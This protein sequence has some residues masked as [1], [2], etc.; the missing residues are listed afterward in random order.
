MPLTFH[1]RLR[2]SMVL[3]LFASPLAAEDWPQFRGPNC[4]G[5]STAK[6]P[7]P[8][9]FSKSQN[10]CWMADLGDAVSS[11]SVADGRVFTTAMLGPRE[12][13]QKFVVFAF[14]AGT[15]RELWQKSFNPVPK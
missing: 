7:L 6:K 5:V 9:K 15:G 8:V 14:D 13:K 10:V 11:P 2:W 3:L 1:K 4:S 12:G